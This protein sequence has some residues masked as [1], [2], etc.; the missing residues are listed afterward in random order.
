ML[1]TL[2][3]LGQLAVAS[4]D[5]GPTPRPTPP[6]PSGQVSTVA[7]TPQ[8]LSGFAGR[9]KLKSGADALFVQDRVPDMRVSDAKP[10]PL[11]SQ[12]G[13]AP[14][15]SKSWRSRIADAR[16]A[17]S[18]AKAELATAEALNPPHR[19]VVTG[20]RAGW[21]ADRPPGAPG[22]PEE[23]AANAQLEQTRN[24]ALTPY[25]IRE[26]STSQALA[27]L[28]SECRSDGKRAQPGDCD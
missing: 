19:V 22:P 5:P 21:T 18:T 25:R 28:V 13:K 27:S 14:D 2:L 6:A 17:Y 1:V 10:A 23:V 16:A 24:A 15:A 3:I 4:P 11:P 26:A 12:P 7:P 8:S 20:G 9:T